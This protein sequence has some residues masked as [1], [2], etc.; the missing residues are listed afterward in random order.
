M[1][2]TQPSSRVSYGK[3]AWLPA[4]L[5][6]RA[7]PIYTRSALVQHTGIA[8]HLMPPVWLRTIWALFDLHCCC[9]AADGA[10][11]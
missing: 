2:H 7:S 6:T 5:R 9:R 8:V 3:A 4:C 1:R 11:A 10:P